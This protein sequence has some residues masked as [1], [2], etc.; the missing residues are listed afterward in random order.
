LTVNLSKLMSLL[1]S[2][3]CSRAPLRAIYPHG[4]TP[5]WTADDILSTVGAP[6]RGV[7]VVPMVNSMVLFPSSPFSP[8]PGQSFMVGS[9][10]W[11]INTNG[12]GEI[13]E[14]V[15]DNLAPVVPSPTPVDPISEP[16]PGSSSSPRIRHPIPHRL[17]KPIAQDD[18]IASIDQVEK[19][20]AE[21][22]S[23]VESVLDRPP[24]DDKFP[25]LQHS[26]VVG[27]KRP[28]R[29]RRP[30]WPY[31]DLII[32][33]TPEGHM[34]QCRPLPRSYLP[35]TDQLA[36]TENVAASQPFGL[37]NLAAAY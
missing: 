10:T 29:S 6:G 32:T 18:L 5:R 28:T 8:A 25:L 23:L 20:L 12:N 24:S 7:H 36:P 17:R 3:S 35:Y 22:L 16:L 31:A 27:V 19:S 26:Q 33:A 2:H 34:V 30:R 1:R 9:I 21:C 13:V 37:A 4:H 14:L 15:R 11:V